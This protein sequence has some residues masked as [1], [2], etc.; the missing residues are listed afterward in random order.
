VFANRRVV[1]VPAALGLAAPTFSHGRAVRAGCRSVV[2]T[3]D[4][5]GVVHVRGTHTLGLV[6]AV[7]G[8]AL[9]TRRVASFAGRVSLFV[10]GRPQAGDPRELLLR[11]RDEIVLE[12]GGYVPP[13]TSY[14][15]PP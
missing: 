11:D 8:Q 10:N 15:F 7:W 13:H 4:P 9:D 12:V 1:I 14:R 6:F 3:T 5:T 2:W